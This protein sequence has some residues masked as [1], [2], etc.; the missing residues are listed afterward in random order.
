VVGLKRSSRLAGEDTYQGQILNGRC[1]YIVCERAEVEPFFVTY[2][3]DDPLGRANSLNLNRDLTASQRALVAAQQLLLDGP[4]KRGP[5][6]GTD[7]TQIPGRASAAVAKHFRVSQTNVEKAKALLEEAPDLFAQDSTCA[8]SLAAAYEQLQARGHQANRDGG[9]ERKCLT[10]ALCTAIMRRLDLTPATAS[11][12]PTAGAPGPAS[13][14]VDRREA[15]QLYTKPV[16]KRLGW[17]AV[18]TLVAVGVYLVAMSAGLPQMPTVGCI[19]V[20]LV[21]GAIVLGWVFKATESGDSPDRK[22]HD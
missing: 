16:L 5:K 7:C 2:E 12:G 14:T 18:L 4:K 8:L 20:G 19:L 9:P 17:T 10:S 6:L 3:G 21:G 22:K 11:Y 13:E 15:V 1:R